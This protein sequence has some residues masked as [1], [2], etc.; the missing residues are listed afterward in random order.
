MFLYKVAQ[1]TSKWK[2][3]K[4]NIFLFQ[5]VV[6]T[7]A[8]V[9]KKTCDNI[10]QFTHVPSNT[11]FL[12]TALFCTLERNLFRYAPLFFGRL[13]LYIWNFPYIEFVLIFFFTLCINNNNN[14]MILRFSLRSEML[15]VAPELLPLTIIP[16][17]PAT[18]KGDVYSFGIILEEIILRKGPFHAARQFLDPQGERLTWKYLTINIPI[19]YKFVG[20]LARVAA[21]ED[22]PFR[23][24]IERMDVPEDLTGLAERC[25]LDSSDDR[26]GFDSIRALLR[27]TVAEYVLML[28]FF[29][30]SISLS[31]EDFRGTCWTIFSIACNN[32][33]TLWK[34]W[35]N[36]RPSCCIR[37]RKNLKNCYTR[38]SFINVKA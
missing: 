16:G 3:L 13:H 20:I 21:R 22:P 30:V 5:K 38:F 37:K 1:L 32:M 8:E 19:T 27:S 34:R 9:K 4:K 17:S 7:I 15:W 33:P 14:W 10:K 2:I 36:R 11:G 18:Q 26:P 23:P 6:L 12:T 35:S 24:A 25:W 29:L 31:V 28:F